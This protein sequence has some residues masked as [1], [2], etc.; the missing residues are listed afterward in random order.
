MPTVSCHRVSQYQ[1]QLASG[2]IDRKGSD[3]LLTEIQDWITSKEK[4]M[5]KKHNHAP[6]FIGSQ[7]C[8]LEC[9]LQMDYDAAKQIWHIIDAD[10]V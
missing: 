9:I 7:R 1:D 10:L 8:S 4:L 5:A 6:V 3:H 2:A